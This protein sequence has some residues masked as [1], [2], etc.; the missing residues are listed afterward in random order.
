MKILEKEKLDKLKEVIDRASA[1]FLTTHLNADGDA[2]GS[3]LALGLLL[4]KAGKEVKIMTPNDFPEFLQWLPGQDLISVFLKDP[5]TTINW[6][7]KADVIFAVDYNE[8]GRLQ[9]AEKYFLESNAF[10]VMIDHHPDPAV[11]VD[12]TVSVTN[13]GSTAELIY[14]LIRDLKFQNLIDQDIATCLFT[15][16]MTDTGCFSFNSS[17]SGVFTAVAELLEYGLDKDSIYRNVYDNYSESRM[18]LMGYCLNEKMVVLPEYNTAYISLT[19]KELKSFKHIPGDT[20]GFVNLPFSIKG[21]RFTAIFLEKKEYIKISF[22]SRGNFDVNDFSAKY[23]NG[24]GHLNAA[25][26]EWK[27]SL[28]NTIKRFVSLLPG[29]KDQL[30]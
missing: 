24:G 15:G 12:L 6:A 18:R 14:Y 4:K 28:E 13:L 23:F 10:K 26:G 16:I 27:Q 8:S 1:I 11:F 30:S 17:Y 19:E 29:L 3:T 7:N 21:I 20:E 5:K 9:K 22:R 2:I 25:G